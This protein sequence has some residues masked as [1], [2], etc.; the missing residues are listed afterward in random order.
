LKAHAAA[1]Q[2]IF[3][4][5][6]NSGLLALSQLIA[7]IAMVILARRLSLAELGSFS[8]LYATTVGVSGIL[9]F[10]SSALWARSLA[11]RPD[12]TAYRHWLVRRTLMQSC[13]VTTVAC[14]MIF[15]GMF[16]P[17]S[18]PAVALLMTQS[19]AITVSSGSLAAV[20]SLQSPLRASAFLAIGN[21]FLLMMVLLDPV[22][23][24][25]TSAS[26]GAATS[27]LLTSLLAL[28]SIRHLPA[29][30]AGT[31]ERNPWAHSAGL[32]IFGLA[33]AIQSF[34]LLILR[35]TAGAAEVGRLAAV[36]RWV[37]PLML[38]PAGFTAAAAPGLASAVTDAEAI[39]LVRSARRLTV[40]VIALCALLF[41][42]A[43]MAIRTLVGTKYHG[44]EP[45]LRLLCVFAALVA[46]NQPTIALL[47]ARG[48]ERFLATLT[49]SVVFGGAAMTS[50]TARPLGAISVPISATAAQAALYVSMRRY[51]RT[52]CA[53]GE[54]GAQ[55]FIPGVDL[56]NSASNRHA[57]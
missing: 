6:A 1:T 8:A 28:L 49:A 51:L 46:I 7:G 16:A 30:P 35:M 19:L 39:T 34:D 10:G 53:S 43:P 24:L 21:I 52:S 22:R 44:S 12:L 17:L 14:P 36:S 47:Q 31:S 57:K 5:V 27:W 4:A 37:L 33:V 38:L 40:V 41:A 23:S 42:V 26:F 54:I 18:R 11:Q 2:S 20:R 55:S 48:H 25:S 45:L 13:V 56:H 29:I 32:G 9:D 15:F 50:I 3:P